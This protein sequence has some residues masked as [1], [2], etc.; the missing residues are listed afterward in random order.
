[1]KY[2]KI[3]KH[4]HEIHDTTVIAWPSKRIILYKQA[5]IYDMTNCCVLRNKHDKQSVVFCTIVTVI[6]HNIH[7]NGKYTFVQLSFSYL[8]VV[9]N[10]INR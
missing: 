10:S 8:S 3:T 6:H 4:F 1:M 7:I 5:H 9:L 2:N